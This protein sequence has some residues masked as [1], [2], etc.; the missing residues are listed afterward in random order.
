MKKTI[1]HFQLG[2]VFLIG[3]NEFISDNNGN[4]LV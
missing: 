2:A 1:G 4:N 3:L